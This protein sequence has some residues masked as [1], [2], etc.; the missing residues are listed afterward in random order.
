MYPSLRLPS[1]HKAA[2]FAR[3]SISALLCAAAIFAAG[4]HHQGNV[5]FYGVAWVTLTDEPGDYTA[6]NV[7]V[8]SVILTR[9]DGMTFTALGTPEIVDFTQLSNVAELWG[10]ATIPDGT[11]V[12]ATITMDY[13]SA[14]I[15]VMVNGAPV[16]ATVV[17][18][19]DLIPTTFVL[20][21]TF[22]PEHPLVVTPTF[23]S[24]SAQP[25]AID[26]NLAASGYVDTSVSPPKV[27]VRPFLTAGVQPADTKLIRIRGPLVNSSTAVSTYTVYVRPFYDE[28]NNLGVL[29]LFNSA[30]TI[31]TINGAAYVGEAGLKAISLLSAGSTMTAAYTTFQPT[32]NPANNAVAGKF[33][34]VYVV[35]GS[36]L[37]DQY[38]EGVSGEVTAR[39]GNTLTLHS[40]TLF[41]NTAD[42][43]LYE[44]VDTNVL[45]GSGTLVTVDDNA[46]LTGLNS[47][48]V[49]VGQHITARGI[50]TVPAS[51][52]ITLDSTGTSATNTG[53]VRLQSTQLWGPLVSSTTGSLVMNLQTINDWPVSAYDFAGNGA[54]TAQNPVPATFSVDTAAVPAPAIPPGVA[55]GDP[56]WIN[57]IFSPFGTAPPDF[58]AFA[59]NSEASVQL[60]GPTP[61]TAGSQTCG[62]GS[63]V[64]VPASLRVLWSNSPGTT[65]PFVGLNAATGFSI[66][67]SNTQLQSA[68]I[69]IGPESIALSTLPGSPQI[70]PTTLPVTSTFSP[71]YTVGNP[72]TA[73][74][75][76]TTTTAATTPTTSLYVYSDFSSFVNQTNTIVS[77][78][79]PAIQFEARGVFNRTANT[80]TATS[81]N[82]VL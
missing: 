20:S 74:S 6:Y 30:S 4:C 8:D 62:I 59:V 2:D 45:L 29:S 27:I 3:K 24:T 12:S 17:D 64:C 37:E 53:S 11:Y 18:A 63:Q 71:R 21:V 52:I 77:A 32:L 22:D 40:S 81:I 73:S 70:V 43:F 1:R 5:S 33:N 9:N 38:T 57:G 69:R 48:S 67:L 76:T 35:A 80:F 7:T 55:A 78:A 26:F 15:G 61:A 42:E 13:T 28:V 19:A 31:F 49:A 23:A 65:T 68:I 54:T 75:S 51:G 82:L 25:L 39:N 36:T 41:L 10:S 72:T 14:V 56:L 46:T 47:S 50:Y 44:T 79:N 16:I 60:A 66:D 34:T 58:E